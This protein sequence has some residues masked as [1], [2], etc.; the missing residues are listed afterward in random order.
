[1]SYYL[2][3]A[4]TKK[5]FPNSLRPCTSTTEKILF[6][7]VSFDYKFFKINLWCLIQSIIRE[8]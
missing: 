1:M 5:F 8:W 6:I 7:K 4:I 2:F 3:S